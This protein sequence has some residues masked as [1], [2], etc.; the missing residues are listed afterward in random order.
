MAGILIF[1]TLF[2]FCPKTTTHNR[3]KLSI[4]KTVLI[5]NELLCRSPGLATA[6]QHRDE[7]AVEHRRSIQAREDRIE[8]VR[9]S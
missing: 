8:S 3:N 1:Y 6:G 7:A 5:K 4:L 2:R 9:L